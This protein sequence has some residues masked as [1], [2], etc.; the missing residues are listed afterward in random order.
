ML[1]GGTVLFDDTVASIN[2][3]AQYIF[4]NDGGLLQVNFTPFIYLFIDSKVVSHLYIDTT[5]V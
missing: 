3:K 1:P 2:L 4:I 5:D